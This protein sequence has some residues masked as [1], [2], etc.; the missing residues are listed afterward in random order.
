MPHRQSGGGLTAR[1][2]GRP[3]GPA[4]DDPAHID[5]R[6]AA[7]H[8]GLDRLS[9]AAQAVLAV[10]VVVGQL[11]RIG[12]IAE[13]ADAAPF[14]AARIHALGRRGG[15]ARDQ[16]A[17]GVDDLVVRIH[18]LDPVG[19]IEPVAVPAGRGDVFVGVVGDDPVGE[20]I[21]G[22]IARRRA[23]AGRP[24][25]VEIAR[26]QR[27][28]AH[29]HRRVEGPIQDQG[30]ARVAPRRHAFVLQ[31]D[32]VAEDVEVEG[33]GPGRIVE[34]DHIEVL[35]QPAL[36]AVA[37]QE[38]VDVVQRRQGADHVLGGPTAEVDPLNRT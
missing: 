31:R 19:R 25:A 6:A 15:Q 22:L 1:T 17:V 2:A 38:Q 4:R 9:A 7:G 36:G 21:Q 35:T 30:T 24:L 32:V 37:E 27:Q 14:A 33:R 10:M 20:Q 16:I 18:H 5:D 29:D 13:E 28:D 3:A 11:S 23:V 26:S 12:A 8:L 34:I